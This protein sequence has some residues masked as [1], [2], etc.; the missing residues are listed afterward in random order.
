MRPS[1]SDYDEYV[2]YPEDSETSKRWAEL[3]SKLDFMDDL[4][5]LDFESST[6]PTILWSSD[7]LDLLLEDTDDAEYIENLPPHQMQTSS[8]V[9]Y[10]HP[11]SSATGDF[12]GLPQLSPD[13]S[14]FS[15][16]SSRSPLTPEGGALLPDLFCHP[17]GAF[18]PLDVAVDCSPFFEQEAFIE[19]SVYPEQLQ[20]DLACQAILNIPSPVSSSRNISQSTIVLPDD[21]AELEPSSILPNSVVR[22]NPATERSRSL[23]LSE[24]LAENITSHAQLCIS[25]RPA[26]CPLHTTV[27]HPT[28][29]SS[30][31]TPHRVSIRTADIRRGVKRRRTNDHDDEDYQPYRIHKRAASSHTQSHAVASRK[32]RKVSPRSLK[33]VP[34]RHEE[35]IEER[36]DCSMQI[37]GCTKSFSRRND[38]E[39]HLGSC[40]FNPDLPLTAV[41]C[42]HCQKSLSRKDALLR[43][44][45]QSHADVQ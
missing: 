41:T 2:V 7:D 43:H 6:A 36:F 8:A 26:P 16:A 13:E 42:P 40:K 28:Q 32:P 30:S 24:G 33:R 23:R 27:R 39:R 1:S 15:V 21:D 12:L 9:R 20:E 5:T 17:P 19:D 31:S 10:R 34:A 18:G 29:L 37:H 38:M 25:P 11:G 44:I 45:K 22:H 35:A 4:R 14:P 3:P